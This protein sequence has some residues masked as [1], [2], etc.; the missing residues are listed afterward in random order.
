MSPCYKTIRVFLLL[1][2]GTKAQPEGVFPALSHNQPLSH[3]QKERQKGV[4][5]IP[6]VSWLRMCVMQA[7]LVFTFPLHT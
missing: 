4:T 5:V 6:S 1:K 7:A 3:N 2:Y